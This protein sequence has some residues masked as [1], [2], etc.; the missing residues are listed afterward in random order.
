MGPRTL[1]V[2]GLLPAFLCVSCSHMPEVNTAGRFCH[3]PVGPGPEDMALLE[4]QGR[5]CLLVSC[6]DRRNKKTEGALRLLDLQTCELTPLSRQNEP[7]QFVLAPQGISV[8]PHSDGSH[9]VFAVN[10]APGGDSVVQYRLAAGKLTFRREYR[11]PLFTRC[12]DIAASPDGQFYVTNPASMLGDLCFPRSTVL[13]CQTRPDG[14]FR[15]EKTIT[16]LKFANGIALT[17]GHLYVSETLGRRLSRWPIRRDG[18]LGQREPVGADLRTVDNLSVPAGHNG[19]VLLLAASAS[20]WSFLCH[21]LSPRFSS[22]TLV[23]RVDAEHG[24]VELIYANRGGARINGGSVA[25]MH[26]GRLYIGQVFGDA[27]EVV[28]IPTQWE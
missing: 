5:P 13:H 22:P 20:V 16:G 9:G 21:T 8:V 24:R 12:N 19:N 6:L 1:C 11:H 15:C 23:W 18:S 28:D 17:G 26:D 7:S 3:I 14:S 25:V 4:T 10:K 2:W 27:I